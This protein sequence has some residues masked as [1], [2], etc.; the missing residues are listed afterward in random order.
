MPLETSLQ[1]YV[2]LR[3][4]ESVTVGW[5]AS[6]GQR[7]VRY[8]LVIREQQLNELQ[9]YRIPNQ[10]GLESR[11]KKSAD[12]KAKYCRDIKQENQYV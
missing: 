5:L 2:S 1:E 8:C 4:C 9:S 6:P 10:C 11:M 12:F 3:E 7:V